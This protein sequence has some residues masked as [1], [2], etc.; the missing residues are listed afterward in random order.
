MGFALRRLKPAAT[1][2]GPLPGPA[3]VASMPFLSNRFSHYGSPF[4]AMNAQNDSMT[5]E[6]M[7]VT[8]C[9]VIDPFEA[10]H[11]RADAGFGTPARGHTVSLPLRKDV[12]YRHEPTMWRVFAV[13]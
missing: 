11:L 1:H 6:C 8:L 13:L 7:D 10:R 3:A 4:S 9:S 12:G 2:G 5:D